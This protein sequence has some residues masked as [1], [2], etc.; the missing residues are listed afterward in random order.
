M[1][2]TI[3]VDG[4]KLGYTTVGEGKPLLVIGSHVYYPRTFSGSLYKHFKFI[5][6]DHRGFGQ[7]T[8]PY[9][10]Q[11]FSLQKL[12]ADIEAMRKHLQ[13]EQLLL[14]GHSGHAYFALEYAKQFPERV[15]HLIL[16]A[17]SPDAKLSSV[18]AA[19]RGFEESV[20]P[21]RKYLLA[22]RLAILEEEI[23]AK[24]RPEFI[25]RLL[26]FSPMLW[27]QADY[28]AT[29]LWEGVHIIPEMFAEVW[30]KCFPTLDI[31]KNLDVLQCP[32]FLGLGRYDYW[33]PPYFW[34]AVRDRFSRLT[35]RVFEQSGHTPQLEEP[36]LFNKILLDWV[37]Q[38]V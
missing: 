8:K 14:L 33:N 25:A 2:K 27:Y 15:S 28:D 21:W 35:I 20:C 32:I 6:M 10:P 18:E 34:E 4:F 12:I 16:L 13:L 36:E 24:T 11:D 7:A 3:E 37:I 38:S 26:A 19:N 23:K 5:F 30:G 22:Q 9:N 1:N 29:P 31:T 17:V